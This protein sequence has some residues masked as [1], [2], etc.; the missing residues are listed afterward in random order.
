M[1]TVADA[2]YFFDGAGIPG[3]TGDSVQ[4]RTTVARVL[5]RDLATNTLTLDRAVSWKAGDGVSLP[6]KGPRP[7]IGAFETGTD[8]WPVPRRRA[9]LR[10]R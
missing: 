4:V 10:Y 8:A 7:D 2:G 3:E 6:W 9:D 1:L 5:K